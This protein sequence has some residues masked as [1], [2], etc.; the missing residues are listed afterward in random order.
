[1]YYQASNINYDATGGQFDIMIP[2]GG[3]AT[4]DEWSE[5]CG[6]VDL[7]KGCGGLLY[8]CE[9]EVGYNGTEQEMYIQRK[10]CLTNKCNEPFLNSQ[11]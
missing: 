8:F 4:S 3:V 6:G 10:Q 5:L 7:G 9:I 11:N 1:M 2:G